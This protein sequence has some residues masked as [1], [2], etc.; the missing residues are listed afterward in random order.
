M[1]R[2]QPR[3]KFSSESKTNEQSGKIEVEI[4]ARPPVECCG[5]GGRHYVKNYL[6]HEVMD[7][8]AYI[9]E[10]SNVGEVARSFPKINASLEDHEVE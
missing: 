3:F 6:Y 9:Q 10:A 1:N 8:V 5:C 4:V 7:Q 2:N